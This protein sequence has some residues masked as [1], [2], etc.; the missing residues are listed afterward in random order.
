MRQTQICW[1]Q[2]LNKKTNI[3][4]NS[5]YQCKQN[6]VNTINQVY[7]CA[8]LP[9]LAAFEASRPAVSAASSITVSTLD[10]YFIKA[11]RIALW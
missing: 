1:L 6:I 3:F 4:I 9:T 10:W 8:F 2:E 7:W 11:G 5:G